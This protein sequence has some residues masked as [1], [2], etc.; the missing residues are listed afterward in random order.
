MCY[1]H[2]GG[3][4]GVAITEALTGH[5]FIREQ[6]GH[7]LLGSRG[8]AGFG[9]FGIDVGH[10]EHRTRPLLRPCLDWSERRYHLAG[11]LG[12]ALTATMM[13]RKWIAIREA[14]RVVTVSQAGT[15]GLRDWMGIDLAHLRAVA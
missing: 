13:N 7:F 8:V 14:S 3:A 5:D 11:S 2:L 12:A 9:E 4:V 10:L 15:D 6:A 1:D